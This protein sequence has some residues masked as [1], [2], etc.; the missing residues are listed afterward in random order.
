MIN[1]LSQ[2]IFGALSRNGL[3]TNDNSYNS[4][5]L[6]YGIEIVI[7]SLIETVIIL[8]I[9]SIVNDIINGLAFIIVFVSTRNYTGGYHANSHSKCTIVI[10]ASV[11]IIHLL[12]VLTFTKSDIVFLSILLIVGTIIVFIFTPIINSNKPINNKHKLLKYKLYSTLLFSSYSFVGVVL[13][14]YNIKVGLTI[15][16]TLILIMIFCIIGLI[17]ERS[18][19]YGS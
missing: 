19:K 8:L 14:E 3:V 4:Q 6:K 18:K 16:Y 13:Y 17:Q 9:S 11:I 10:S 5:M 12:C 15:I 7:S 2:S 1:K